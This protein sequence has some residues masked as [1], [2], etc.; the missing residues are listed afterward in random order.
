MSGR[1][2]ITGARAPAALDLA[3]SFRAAGYEPHMADS[4][5][6]RMARLSRAPKAVHRHAPPRQDPAQFRADLA[7]LVRRLDPVLIVPTCEEVF[8]LAAAAE[9]LGLEPRLFAPGIETLG[10]LHSKTAF[11]KHCRRLGL[12]APAS[13]R[14][15][16]YLGL[17]K[18]TPEADRR[19]FKPEFSRAGV[20]T[21]VRPA[22]RAAARLKPTPRDPWCVQ[23][24]VAGRELCFY[25]VAVEGRLAAF[26]AYAPAW[27]MRGGASYAFEP[28]EA[29]LA[30]R[31]QAIAARLAV[32]VHRGQFA[33]DLI[34]DADG[35]PWLI[36]CNPRATSGVH[37]FGQGPELARA[38]MGG[39]PAAPTPELRMLGPAMWLFGLPRA[40]ADGA[41]QRWKADYRRGLDVVGAPGD[42][43]PVLG[44]LMDSL[45][46]QV[47]AFA[48]G[49]P[50]AAEMTS[51]IE[52]N[53]EPL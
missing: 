4:T 37:L 22:P 43:L 46:F 48:R 40:A 28:V 49:R 18:L 27:Q 42:D 34:V 15:T 17:G 3:R 7:A 29:D 19:V 51:D 45:R 30:K 47:A 50:L 5:P 38:I 14:V 6:A 39:A 32:Y 33:C 13:V 53:G 35:E 16:D 41:L 9:A 21:L 10:R 24:A 20:R 52:W 23:D 36:E 8:H 2:L 31:L 44:A 11:A 25:G 12:R 26:A 1:V